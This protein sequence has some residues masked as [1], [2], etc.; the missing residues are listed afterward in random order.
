MK[1]TINNMI[2][3]T[4]YASCFKEWE[5]TQDAYVVKLK[6]KDKK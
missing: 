4:T 5:L 3:P 6:Q 1:G 2:N